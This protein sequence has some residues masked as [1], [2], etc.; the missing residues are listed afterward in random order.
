MSKGMIKIEVRDGKTTSF[1]E[2]V[3]W[4]SD[5]NILKSILL[6]LFEENGG[7]VTKKE[8][9]AA[10]GKI[11]LESMDDAERLRGEVF[12]IFVTASND[13]GA[14]SS[15]AIYNCKPLTRVMNELVFEA[16]SITPWSSIQPATIYTVG[17]P[18][19]PWPF[20]QGQAREASD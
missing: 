19:P 20:L 5:G 17:M 13:Y 15:M 12:S 4:G 6:D 8:H 9:P 18:P 14:S 3:T 2:G 16:E 1:G 7:P 11:R 10:Y